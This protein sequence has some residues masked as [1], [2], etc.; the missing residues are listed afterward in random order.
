M[1]SYFGKMIS[2]AWSRS[3]SSRLSPKTTCP[4]PP[5]C[6]TGAHSDATITTNTAASPFLSPAGPSDSRART[7]AWP[8]AVRA[9]GRGR[10]APTWPGASIRVRRPCAADRAPPPARSATG[11]GPRRR[12]TCGGPRRP[13]PAGTGRRPAAAGLPGG[14]V[15]RLLAGPGLHHLVIELPGTGVLSDHDA[16]QWHRRYLIGALTPGESARPG[17]VACIS[18]ALAFA[19]LSAPVT[20]SASSLRQLPG[21]EACR[22]P[23]LWHLSIVTRRVDLGKRYDSRVAAGYVI[24]PG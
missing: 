15:R 24:R 19:W 9:P 21:V 10:P 17:A 6:A 3:S 4:S 2:T 1:Q 14:Q 12:R 7:G 22:K 11:S 16:E 8:R 18:R 23:G 20:L 13:A 5:A